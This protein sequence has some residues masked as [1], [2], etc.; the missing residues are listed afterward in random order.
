MVPLEISDLSSDRIYIHCTC[1]N[2][3]DIPPC[4]KSNNSECDL[5]KHWGRA[6][7]KCLC[8]PMHPTMNDIPAHSMDTIQ[9]TDQ[10]CNSP[11]CG[12]PG[13]GAT[14]RLFV[15]L[16]A[17]QYLYRTIYHSVLS[18]NHMEPLQLPRRRALHGARTNGIVRV[19]P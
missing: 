2:V 15:H 18:Y 12:V 13:G 7:S 16:G 1:F 5:R 19:H 11:P 17:C 8:V 14:P 6:F 4:D 10:Q 3:A 9:I